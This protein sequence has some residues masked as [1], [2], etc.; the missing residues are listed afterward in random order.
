M[1]IHWPGWGGHGSPVI[2]SADLRLS[3]DKGGRTPCRF[4]N[5]SPSWSVTVL[6]K[7]PN[8]S[9]EGMQEGS[10]IDLLQGLL[11]VVHGHRDIQGANAVGLLQA[12]V[13]AWARGTTYMTSYQT[14]YLLTQSLT[15]HCISKEHTFS[16][17]DQ[18]ANKQMGVFSKKI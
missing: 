9:T 17:N 6:L 2:W 4:W 8:V 12:A 16:D 3:N 18:P 1:L 7:D 15:F 14:R 5:P 11:T 10:D 13:H